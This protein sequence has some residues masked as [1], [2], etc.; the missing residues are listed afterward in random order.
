M[1]RNLSVTI[2]LLSM[3]A[4]LCAHGSEQHVMGTVTNITETAIT[5]KTQ[6]G[7]SVEVFVGQDTK[8]MRGGQPISAKDVKQGD[9]IVIH[10]NKKGEKLTATTVAIGKAN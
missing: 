1:R 5:V 8:F 7:N 9:R 3:T 10:A 2:L 4:M 6:D